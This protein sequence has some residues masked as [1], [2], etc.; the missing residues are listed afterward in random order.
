MTPIFQKSISDVL[1]IFRT[2][3]I[4]ALALALAEVG[5]GVGSG[6][7][8]APSIILKGG[9]GP[10][11]ISPCLYYIRCYRAVIVDLLVG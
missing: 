3:D 8:M 9:P 1:Y 5:S 11:N 7:P 10:P 2:S 4:P 6:G